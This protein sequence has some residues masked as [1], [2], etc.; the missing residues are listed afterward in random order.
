MLKSHNHTKKQT[1]SI[2]RTNKTS[3]RIQKQLYS[4]LILLFRLS[5]SPALISTMTLSDFEWLS[6]IYNDTKRRAISLRQMSF[7]F[8]N[9]CRDGRGGLHAFAYTRL[10]HMQTT[11]W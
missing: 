6:K 7:L 11:L 2:Y 5:D 4:V 8:S 3:Y 1:C 9:V 10:I